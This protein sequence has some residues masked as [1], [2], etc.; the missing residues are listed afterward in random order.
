MSEVEQSV[1]GTLLAAGKSLAT[2]E[3]LTAGLLAA[4]IANVPG[5]SGTLVGGIISYNNQIKTE[6]LGV[7]DALLREQGAVC[8]AVAE[9]MASGAASRLNTDY[10]LSTTGVAGP[11]PHQGKA[12]GTVFIGVHTPQRTWAEEFK[13]SGNRDQI[14]Q[15]TVVAALSML[16]RALK[17]PAK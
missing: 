6:L 15:A 9:Q 3:S 13:L 2:A 1:V 17:E 16:A 12:V 11:E 10:A 4:A 14:R 8:A 5:A 7:D